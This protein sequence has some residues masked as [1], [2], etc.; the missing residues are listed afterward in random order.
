MVR[1]LE[2]KPLEEWLR[3]LGVFSL[4]E[5]DQTSLGSTASSGGAAPTSAL[6]DSDSS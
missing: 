6:Q 3:S 4:K 2:G 1:G 5:T